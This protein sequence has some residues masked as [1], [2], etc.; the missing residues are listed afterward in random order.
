MKIEYK[1]FR[2]LLFAVLS[3]PFF[4]FGIGIIKMQVYEHLFYGDIKEAV[5]VD[6]T[7]DI[8]PSSG[9]Y[10]GALIY[11]VVTTDSSKAVYGASI[12][13]YNSVIKDQEDQYANYTSD[14]GDTVEIKVLSS[15]SAKILKLNG[16]QIAMDFSFWSI[17]WK[18]LLALLLLSIGGFLLF[19]AY[20]TFKIKTSWT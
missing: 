18:W 20:L 5:I 7:H 14:L 9:Q 12:A 11:Q 19:K 2:I 8:G 17:F 1:I 10:G 15:Y 6:K 4:F 3:I 13:T 16:K